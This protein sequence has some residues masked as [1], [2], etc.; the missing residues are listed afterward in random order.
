MAPT[1][2]SRFNRKSFLFSHPLEGDESVERILDD[3]PLSATEYVWGKSTTDY[4]TLYTLEA[5]A[6]VAY[7]SGSGCANLPDR[8]AAWQWFIANNNAYILHA[9]CSD[10]VTNTDTSPH[11]LQGVAASRII[12]LYRARRGFVR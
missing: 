6:A 11:V 5:F 8:R 9:F 4:Y 12:A 2:G 7:F 1:S 10:W 3:A